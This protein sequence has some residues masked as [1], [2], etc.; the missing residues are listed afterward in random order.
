LA[1]R[2]GRENLGGTSSQ[3]KWLYRLLFARYPTDAEMEIAT[4]AIRLEG[5]AKF[6][7]VLLCTNEF[8]Y[9]D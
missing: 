7:Q 5:L 1:E 9:I 2:I 4:D 3:I 8:T 6:C